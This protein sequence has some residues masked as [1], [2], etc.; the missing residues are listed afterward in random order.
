VIIIL[1]IIIGIVIFLKLLEATGKAFPY[2]VVYGGIYTLSF[3]IWHWV[4]WAIAIFFTIGFAK[5]MW[6]DAYKKRGVG[7]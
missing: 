5:M 2:V 7:L 6:D 3:Y 4:C 1:F